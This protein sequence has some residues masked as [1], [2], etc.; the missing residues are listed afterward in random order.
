VLG[1]N[2]VRYGQVLVKNSHG[3]HAD[4]VYQKC[5]HLIPFA[6]EHFINTYRKRA[7]FVRHP[8]T[9]LRSYW[10][11]RWKHH[12]STMGW[13]PQRIFDGQTYPY[14]KVF[15]QWIDR[16]YELYPR[17]F[18]Y[19]IYLDYTSQ[20]TFVGRME[21]IASDLKFFMEG[22]EKKKIKTDYPPSNVGD[23]EWLEKAKYRSWGQAKMVMEKEQFIWR[24]HGYNYIPEGICGI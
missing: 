11:F 20:C 7:C 13:Q 6:N 10:A 21:N 2:A 8:L 19:R 12:G 1:Q 24:F 18:L 23:P 14:A 15:H 17:G 4:L 3:A 22:Y 5:Q 16:I 9:W